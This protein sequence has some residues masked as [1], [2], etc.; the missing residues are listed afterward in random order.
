MGT[1]TASTTFHRRL[2]VLLGLVLGVVFALLLAGTAQAGGNCSI[3]V[4][5]E[6]VPEGGQYVVSGN[7]GGAEIHIVRGEN[8]AT[9]EDSEPVVTVPLNRT[10]FEV[11]ITAGPGSV[12][13]WTVWGFIEGS[14]CG[15][16]ALVTVTSVPDTSMDESGLLMATAVGASLL[17]LAIASLL[18]VRASKRQRS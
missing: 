16:S 15:D 2:P 8:V 11:T 7:F 18:P 10:T 12:G 13:V 3:S 4:D 9:P 5:P 6:T 17:V 1:P 14:E